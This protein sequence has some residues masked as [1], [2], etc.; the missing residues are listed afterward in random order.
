MTGKDRYIKLCTQTLSNDYCTAL[1]KSRSE[2]NALD[3]VKPRIFDAETPED[4]KA[5]AQDAI[6]ALQDAIKAFE[7]VIE[8]ADGYNEVAH[9][10][11]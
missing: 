1:L 9:G 3:M 6:K 4:V 5:R 8:D 11:A 7:A 10:V 2:L